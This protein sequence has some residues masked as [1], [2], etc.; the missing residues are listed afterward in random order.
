MSQDKKKNVAHIVFHQ[1]RSIAK[2]N[3]EDFSLLLARWLVTPTTT[4]AT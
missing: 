4:T 2:T 3:N 1:L